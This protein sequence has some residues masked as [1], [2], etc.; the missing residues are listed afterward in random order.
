VDT[1]A[2]I[3]D[4]TRRAILDMLAGREQSAGALVAAFPGLTQPAVSRHLRVLREVGLVGVRPVGQLR[5]YTLRAESLRE[6]EGWLARY[7]AFWPAQLDALERHLAKSA[8]P[9]PPSP[10]KDPP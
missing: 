6:V 10:P 4:P 3:A 9:E 5:M 1:F 8:P 2:A 7:R